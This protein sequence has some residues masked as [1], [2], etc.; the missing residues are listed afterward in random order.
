VDGTETHPFRFINPDYMRLV[1]WE[2]AGKKAVGYGYDS[3]EANV[4]SV[5]RLRQ[6]SLGLA[7]DAAL[8]KRQVILDD[9]DSKGIIATPKNSAVN[10]LVLEAGRLSITNEGRAV[11]ITYGASAGV[12]LR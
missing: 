7:A 11:A 5:Q 1:A 9:I 6:A 10:E 4:L 2:G 8:R 3:I 12:K